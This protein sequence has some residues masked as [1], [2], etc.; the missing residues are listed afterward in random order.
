VTHLSLPAWYRQTDLTLSLH[1]EVP[2]QYE[3]DGPVLVHRS[4]VTGPGPCWT[5]LL[6]ANTPRYA[7]Q[8]YQQ[9]A[10]AYQRLGPPPTSEWFESA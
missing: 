6:R 2:L 4:M 1:A 9:L 8:P 3:E 10:A 5:A 7:A